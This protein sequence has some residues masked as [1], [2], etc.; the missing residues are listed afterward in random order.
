MKF[1]GKIITDETKNGGNVPSLEVFGVVLDQC[2]LAD[3]YIH[4]KWKDSHKKWKDSLERR[5]TFS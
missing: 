2:K 4:K 5:A 1:F 3:S